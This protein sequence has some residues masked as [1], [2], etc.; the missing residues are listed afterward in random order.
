MAKLRQI[1]IKGF[2]YKTSSGACGVCGKEDKPVVEVGD[3]TRLSIC[4]ECAQGILDIHTNYKLMMT[5]SY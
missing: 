4:D 2:G 1:K 5:G 3:I